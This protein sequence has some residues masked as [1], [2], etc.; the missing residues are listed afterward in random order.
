[1]FQTQL[2]NVG[3]GALKNREDPNER[4]GKNIQHLGPATDFYKKLSLECSAQQVAVDM[5]LLNSQYADM[6]TVGEE[7]KLK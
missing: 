7:A 5:F 1:M 3:P 2:P 4:A 6:A